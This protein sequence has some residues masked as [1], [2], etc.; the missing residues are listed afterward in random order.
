[1]SK[2]LF[3]LED[4]DCS[5]MDEI[6]QR[7][8]KRGSEDNPS[9]LL[10]LVP[11]GCMTPLPFINSPGSEEWEDVKNKLSA[12][13]KK[14]QTSSHEEEEDQLTLADLLEVFDGVME[15]KGVSQ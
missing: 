4:I 8:S 14:S 13:V 6:V 15:M 2:R 1:M 11:S 10:P 5:G 3:V 9:K 7:R 12:E